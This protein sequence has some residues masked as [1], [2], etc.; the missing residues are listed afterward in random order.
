[1]SNHDKHVKDVN[2]NLTRIRNNDHNPEAREE[3][4]AAIT[5]GWKQYNKDKARGK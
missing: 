4:S 3:A 2:K 5:A 1:M